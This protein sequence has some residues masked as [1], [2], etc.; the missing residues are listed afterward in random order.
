MRGF[1]V[2]HQLTTDI[3]LVPGDSE[4]E[5][6]EDPRPDG[7]TSPPGHETILFR[8]VDGR[9]SCGFWKRGPET[10]PLEPT[11]DEIM[12]FLQGEIEIAQDDG[13]RLRVGR[14][15]ILAAPNGS[16][17]R[18]RSLSPVYKLWAVHHGTVGNTRVTSMHGQGVEW[19]PSSLPPDDG[20]ERG[21]EAVAFQAGAFTAGLWER[22]RQD[23]DFERD[24]DEVAM[25]LA[26]EAEITTESGESL[27]VGPGDVLVTPKGS[28]GH[29]RSDAPVRKFFATYEF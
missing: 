11:F 28:H 15:D 13:P 22:D 19:S 8:S 3:S 10:G 7:D 4:F 26:G 25:F 29:W 1:R 20:F 27:L 23:R 12:C 6:T 17:A 14:G 9:F 5:W 21:R 24:Y 16:S 2:S 18:W